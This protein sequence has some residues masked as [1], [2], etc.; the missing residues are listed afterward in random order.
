MKS[1]LFQ[2]KA[3]LSEEQQSSLNSFAKL[4]SEQIKKI[5]EVYEEY[6]FKGVKMHDDSLLAKLPDT[7]F[8]IEDIR[9]AF[10]FALAII[11][12]AVKK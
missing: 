12:V 7:E 11:N 8:A 4:D 9:G 3:K 10:V 2:K 1:K 6:V 5:F